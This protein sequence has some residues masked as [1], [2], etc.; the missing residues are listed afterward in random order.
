MG[1]RGRLHLL[2]ARRTSRRASRLFSGK[3]GPVRLHQLCERL[4]E[5]PRPTTSSPSRP[6][7][8]TRSGTTRATRSRARSGCS[9]P[10]A[11][12]ASR[13]PS[14]G[15]RS[16]TATPIVP[17]A[18]Q[19]LAEELH[20]RRPHAQGPAAHH[21]RATG[22]RSG[23]SPTTPTS[24]RALSASSGTPGRSGHA[25]HITSDE[26]LTWD[27]IYGMTAEAA[28]V[29]GAQGSSTSPPTSSPPASPR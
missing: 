1:R 28:G 29:A 15:R 17:L 5:A 14:S 21:S 23:R 4:P 2:H 19:Q 8:P 18:G 25:F 12:R 13:S 7:S 16:P 27:Q 6:R 11:R 10:T 22:S 26:A 24:P 3:A 9:G 20:G